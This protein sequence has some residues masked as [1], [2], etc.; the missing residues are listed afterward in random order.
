[1]RGREQ[2]LSTVL[3]GGEKGGW[4]KKKTG[5]GSESCAM[6]RRGAVGGGWWWWWW[7]VARG[8]GIWRRCGRTSC[9]FAAV[10][11]LEL[12]LLVSAGFDSVGATRR[13]ATR[14]RP[15]SDFCPSTVV[16][17]RGRLRPTNS[18]GDVAFE[19]P[20]TKSGLKRAL[21]GFGPNP[22]LFTSERVPIV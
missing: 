15:L 11:G 8:V 17:W 1:M 10:V 2:S 19:I 22:I 18:S 13:D 12:R 21:F 20:A 3:A 5:W 9:R 14:V 6:M 7:S 4:E 16:G